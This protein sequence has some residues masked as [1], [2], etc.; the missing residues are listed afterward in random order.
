MNTTFVEE[1]VSAYLAQDLT[2]KKAVLGPGSDSVPA[3]LD[4]PVLRHPMTLLPAEGE[5]AEIDEAGVATAS[6][7]ELAVGIAANYYS[8][9]KE[10][11]PV[12][13]EGV[14]AAV[15]TAYYFPLAAASFAAA[16][17]VVACIAAD[18]WLNSL[19][20]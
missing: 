10:K 2:K 13:A 20:S 9:G 1:G 3:K 7:L 19:G 17:A 16:A 12:V 8:V 5:P 14:E 15:E 11:I 6:S 4:P 18:S